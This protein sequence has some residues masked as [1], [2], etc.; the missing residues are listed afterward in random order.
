[1]LRL[2]VLVK[3][4]QEEALVERNILEITTARP[5]VIQNARNITVSIYFLFFSSFK[6]QTIFLI[7]VTTSETA[8][9]K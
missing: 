1:M 8:F 2:T 9:W 7:A 3:T 6:Y 5:P 4:G